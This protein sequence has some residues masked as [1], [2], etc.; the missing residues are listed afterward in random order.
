MSLSEPHDQKKARSSVPTSNAS[1]TKSTGAPRP[2]SN[3][4]P[5]NVGRGWSTTLG[6]VGL[7]VYR[8]DWSPRPRTAGARHGWMINWT[9]FFPPFGPDHVSRAL[10]AWD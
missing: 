3:R 4:S 7:N 10:Y 1:A 5:F 6:R 2:P 8:Y 9:R